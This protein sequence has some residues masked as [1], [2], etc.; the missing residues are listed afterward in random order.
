MLWF[1]LLAFTLLLAFPAFAQTFPPLTGRI[2]DQANLLSPEQAAALDAKLAALEQQ[3]GRQMVVA[4]VASLQDHPIEDYGY[5][6]GRAWGLGDK[7]A[8][9]GLILLVAPTERKVRIE[10]GYGLEPI[11]TD[12][13]ANRIVQGEILP[14]FRDDDI[15]GGILAGANAI[16]EQM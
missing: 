3:S 16:A 14:R 8:N 5:R 7:K 2:V 9:D 4:T 15:P 11:M 10:V 13:L 12:A 1:V 6:L